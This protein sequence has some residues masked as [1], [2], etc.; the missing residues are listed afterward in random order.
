M[1]A[2]NAAGLAHGR[3]G[4]GITLSGLIG[5]VRRLIGL[6]IGRVI[7][8]GVCRLILGLELCA[9]CLL[10]EFPPSNRDG[11]RRRAPPCLQIR[12]WLGIGICGSF[13]PCGRKRRARARP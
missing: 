1:L 8:L 6:G 7:D 13:A 11:S 3:R 5:S 10:H 2:P 4:G 9:S 12:G